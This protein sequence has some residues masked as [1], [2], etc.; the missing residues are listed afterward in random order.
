MD[1]AWYGTIAQMDTDLPYFIE[2]MT[3]DEH[4][5]C[6]ALLANLPYPDYKVALGVTIMPEWI[7]CI[8]QTPEYWLV[9]R[10]IA[11]DTP[12]SSDWDKVAVQARKLAA[13]HGMEGCRVYAS[14][15]SLQSQLPAING[16]TQSL[17]PSRL[18]DFISE[19]NQMQTNNPAN[20]PAEFST[21]EPNEAREAQ[22]AIS[23]Q[24][25]M[26]QLLT[27]LFDGF[28]GTAQECATSLR[29]IG[30][31]LYVTQ[32]LALGELYCRQ[33]GEGAHILISP[34]AYNLLV[35]REENDENNFNCERRIA[36]LAWGD[37]LRWLGKWRPAGNDEEKQAVLDF[38]KKMLLCSTEG[39]VI[40][41]PP[42]TEMLGTYRALLDAGFLPLS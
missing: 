30:Q 18:I 22:W 27:A 33:R 9:I 5:T 12:R 36:L 13:C 23:R 39:V 8:L 10:F 29:R 32:D 42:S 11:R 7:H 16:Q 17:P 19:L 38:Y 28:L 15:I 20:A 35:L 21:I 31:A 2:D 40:Y 37:D 14:I 41:M 1:A 25:S 3:V 6:L 4:D 26:N 34:R 24:N